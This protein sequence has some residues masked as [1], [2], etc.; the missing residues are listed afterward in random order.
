MAGRPDN[1][2]VLPGQG[3]AGNGLPGI[4]VVRATGYLDELGCH[5]QQF[6]PQSSWSAQRWMIASTPFRMRLTGA[7]KGLGALA[8]MSNG[9]GPHWIRWA[10]ELSD[11]RLEAARW[12]EDVEACLYTL[13]CAET[14]PAERARL[15]MKFAYCRRELL[16]VLGEIQHLVAQRFPAALPES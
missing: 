15:A 4:E 13:Q 8:S 16:K 5:L 2:I 1:L 3:E 7:R 12:L 9:A 11:V 6:S 14:L 10:F